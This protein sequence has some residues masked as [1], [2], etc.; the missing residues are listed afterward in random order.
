MADEPNIEEQ[1]EQPEAPK[2]LPART[3][4]AADEKGVMAV[5]PRNTEEAGRYAKAIIAAGVVPDAYT[6]QKDVF[7]RG[8]GEAIV[9]KGDP[10][11]NLIIMGILKS[12][13]VGLPPLTGLGTIVPINNRFT[14]WGDGAIALIQRDRVIAKHT[15]NRVGHN[16]PPDTELADWPAD[17]GWEIRY[18]RKGQDEPYIGKFTVRDAK[19]AGLWMSKRDPWVKY[20]DRMLYNRARAFALR[21]GFADCLHGLGIAE[22]VR[23]TLPEVVDGGDLKSHRLSALDDEPDTRQIEQEHSLNTN[24][25][26]DEPERVSS[27][28]E[29][30]EEPKLV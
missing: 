6:H 3:P 23:D 18:W 2:N 5:I 4:L 24:A 12:L 13:E 15:E 17:Y 19:R 10:D 30:G 9:R 22:E 16:F 20:P 26:D 28:R 7:E 21:D 8:T 1:G 14:I 25:L 11:I 29:D 27:E